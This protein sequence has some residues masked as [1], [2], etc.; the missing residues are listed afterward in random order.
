[1]NAL[2]HAARLR[3]MKSWTS[4]SLCPR[5]HKRRTLLLS[6][7]LGPNHNAAQGSAASAQRELGQRDSSGGS[8]SVPSG[9]ELRV[10]ASCWEHFGKA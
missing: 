10:S 2:V 7:F 3:G 6:Q 1:M 5:Y 4:C 9:V 8:E